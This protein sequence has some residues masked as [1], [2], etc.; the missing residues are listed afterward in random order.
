MRIDVPLSNATTRI[1]R[2]RSNRPALATR[3]AAILALGAIAISGC[4]DSM[5]DPEIP[6]TELIARDKAADGRAAR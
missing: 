5:T 3:A 1:S 4:K 6:F 2:D